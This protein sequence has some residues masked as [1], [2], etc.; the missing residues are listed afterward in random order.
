MY[1]VNE[2][3]RECRRI[4]FFEFLERN[5]FESPDRKNGKKCGQM[6]QG[7]QINFFDLLMN[8]IKFVCDIK[9]RT[10]QDKK[11][12]REACTNYHQR[13]IWVDFV[14]LTVWKDINTT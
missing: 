4:A 10:V 7:Q 11:L 14:I 5:F 9:S 2:S 12:V 3:R 8:R 1:D 13:C 6:K